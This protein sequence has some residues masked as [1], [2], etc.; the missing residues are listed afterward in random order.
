MNETEDRSGGH[1]AFPLF[2]CWFGRRHFGYGGAAT[3]ASRPSPLL[4]LFA[5]QLPKTDLEGRGG[6]QS[7]P[8]G[9]R[10]GNEASRERLGTWVG[11]VLG[12]R[13]RS[14]WKW[15]RMGLASH[16]GLP[17]S[18]VSAGLPGLAGL[19]VTSDA[20]SQDER[21][22]SWGRKANGDEGAQLP[23]PG[24]RRQTASFVIPPPGGEGFKARL[25]CRTE[26]WG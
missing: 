15:R 14:R 1:P 8:E 22:W 4:I 20:D 6:G 16:R 26:R 13:A 24:Q 25:G 7:T 9:M 5:L 19:R 10:V 17:S 11:E 2:P 21:G 18:A 12:W 3:S 23:N